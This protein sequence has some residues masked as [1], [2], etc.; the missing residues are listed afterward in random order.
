MARLSGT[1]LVADDLY[2]MAHDDVTGRPLLQ[3]RAAGLGLAAGLLAE[4][5]LTDLTGKIGI[6]RGRIVVTD[7]SPPGDQLGHGVLGLVLNEREP[8]TV[9]DWLAF[10][11]RSAATDV[12]IRL[13]RSG[14]LAPAGQRRR[15]RAVRW[16]P[17]DPDCAF[18]TLGRARPAL[19]GS[20][21]VTTH[22]ATLAGLAVACG[23]GSRLLPYG[24][25]EARSH[26][27]NTLARLPSGLRELIAQTQAAVDSAVL[28][29][30]T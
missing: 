7:P 8:H 11:A 22:G 12:A 5:M 18:A 6:L 4:L 3:P 1:G 16:V 20:G 29:Q 10:F 23:L 17:I 19:D 27:S 24:P 28:C 21:A 15:S 25:P 30:R 26:L 13:Q 9:R 14:Y 2:L